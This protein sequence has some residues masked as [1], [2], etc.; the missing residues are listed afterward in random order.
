MNAEDLKADWETREKDSRTNGLAFGGLV[1]LV[2]LIAGG[3]GRDDYRDLILCIGG[4][5]ANGVVVEVDDHLEDHP[6]G[7]TVNVHTIYYRFTAR[8]GHRYSGHANEGKLR[9][10][11]PKYTG[12]NQTEQHSPVPVD[13]DSDDTGATVI[14]EY[15]PRNPT[16]HD[17]RFSR[18]PESLVP[19]LLKVIV[20]SAALVACI[21]PSGLVLVRLAR[22]RFAQRA[23]ARA[24]R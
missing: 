7:G 6:S 18:A 24:M 9:Y 5:F 1:L 12:V 16:I 14:V 20:S 10:T 11:D 21:W 23:A 2:L 8:D 17:L 3:W 4:E 19:V 22:R 13:E 15:L